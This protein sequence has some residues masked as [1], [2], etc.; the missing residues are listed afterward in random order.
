MLL[1]AQRLFLFHLG[2]PA[3]SLLVLAQRDQSPSTVDLLGVKVA[4]TGEVT[5]I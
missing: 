3:L 5:Q 2:Q 4:N 1:P